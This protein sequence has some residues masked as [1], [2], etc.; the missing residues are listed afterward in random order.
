MEHN[1]SNELYE[2]LRY[3]GD[4][5][6]KIY[7]TRVSGL[8]V[9]FTSIDPFNVIR[10]IKDIARDEPW[11]IRY[12]LRLIPIQIVVNACIEE[13]SKEALKLASVIKDDESYKVKV[14]KRHTSIHSRDVIEAIA[15]KIDRKVKLDNPDWIILVEIIAKDAGISVLKEQD[16][17]S[18]EKFRRML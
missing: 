14:E 16:I 1:L 15:S 11:R 7:H 8:I 17:F 6:A 10:R 2:L 9:C 18:L 5:D 3:L 13:I 12:L 4:D